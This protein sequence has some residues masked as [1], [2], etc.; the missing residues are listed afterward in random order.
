MRKREGAQ[1]NGVYSTTHTEPQVFG[2]N[3]ALAPCHQMHGNGPERTGHTAAFPNT[4]DAKRTVNHP[5]CVDWKKVWASKRRLSPERRRIEPMPSTRL[6]SE[7][8]ISFE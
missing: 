4:N 2:W 5:N 6:G 1:W 8:V 7:D 3:G